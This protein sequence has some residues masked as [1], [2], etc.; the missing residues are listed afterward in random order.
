MI[1]A[2]VTRNAITLIALLWLAV[3]AYSQRATVSVAGQIRDSSNAAVPT[4]RV[5]VRNLSTG[6]ERSVLSNEEG[7]YVVSALQAGSY[8]VTVSHEGFQVYQVS[9]LLLQVDQQATVNVELRVGSVADTVNVMADAA[10]VELRGAT[11]NTVVNQKMI[12]DL[13]LN[14][15][16]VLQLMNLT[17]GTLAVTGNWN[18]SSTR[19]EAASQ[20]VSASGG[21]GNSTTFVMDGGLN[22]DPYTE[23]AN[24]LPNPDA[25]QEFSFQTNNYGAKFGG[26]G[27]GVVNV[28]TRSGTNEIHGSAFAYVR[29]A[30]LNARN[31]FAS[32]NDGLKRNQFGFS[33]GGPIQRNKTFV[34]GSWQGTEVRQVPPTQTAIVPTA[35]LRR[36][37]F[38]QLGRT[39]TDP[40]TGQ[41][42][43]GNV[44]PTS[45]LDP[46]ALRV[47]DLVPV[48]PA[49]DG[50][51]FFERATPSS[52]YQ[53][54]IRGDHYF[55]SA[56]HISARHFWDRYEN[57]AIADP[58]NL[59]TAANSKF[60]T[61]QSAVA[62]YTYTARANLLMNTTLS[63][64]RVLPTGTAPDFP[65]HRDLGI[66]I[67]SLANPNYSVF[68]MSISDYFGLS[69]YALSRIPRTQYNLQHSWSWVKG[70]H[71]IGFGADI[72]RELSLIDQDFQSDGNYAFAGRYS[73]NNMADFLL[74]KPSAFN[75]IT[76]LYVN[77]VRNLYGLYFED[78]FKVNRRLTLNLGLRWNPFIPFTDIPANQISQFSQAAY[79]AGTKSARFP[80]LGKGHLVAGDPGVPTSG[81]YSRYGV[82]D[83][84]L[85]MAWD[86][87][88]N[89]K[90]A[91]RAG[92]GRF[93]DQMSALTY[94]RQLTS[95][96]NS[97]R[98][99]ITAPFST[100]DPYRGYAN[101]FP[102][103]RPIPSSQ[104]FP[105]PYLLV[106]YDPA[107][108]YPD[109][110]Q[111][112]FSV[113]H[114]FASS[115]VLRAS[116]Q[117][118]TGRNLF[119]ASELNPAIYGP[120]ANRTNTDRRRPRPEFTQLTYAGTYGRSNYNALVLSLERR[121]TSRVTF[122]AGFSWQKTMDILSGTAFEGNGNTHPYGQIDLDYGVSN[123]HR[124]ARFTGSFNYELPS[125]VRSGAL[126]YLVNGWQMNGIVILQSGGPLTI[127]TGVDNSFSGINQD[128]VDIVGNPRLDWGRP[129]AERIARWFDT[130]AFVDNAPGTFGTIGRNTERGPGF[131]NVDFSAFKS[132]PMPYSENHHLEFRFEAFNFLNRVNLNNPTT[133][134][135]SSLFGRITSA[136]DPRILQLGLRYRF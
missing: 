7:F 28:V 58:K 68:S 131:A 123:F 66:D 12:T 87:F 120:G 49:D 107:F 37:D 40:A 116:Y 74:G 73:G 9:D 82:F 95:P 11:I 20:L 43:P 122:L 67:A 27:G 85:G 38:S 92:F 77:L 53:F 69:W 70:R 133:T 15:R 31:F 76:P 136:G 54:L 1:H 4:A 83:P 18:Q 84:R 86:V 35:A 72:T 124:A 135:S 36:G 5:V 111:W 80:T 115:M 52:D 88:G 57:P 10:A 119:H 44:I 129:T 2:V 23:V 62:N 59:L 113:E 61:S 6:V 81:V 32:R 127:A 103:P 97:V 39:I 21:R 112:N 50:L 17:P 117:G 16:N 93:H 105:M 19:P 8:S 14:G 13:P 3:P 130:S 41:P 99:D 109:I 29:N 25:V 78:N 90:T 47:L 100:Q 94:N 30:A 128:R 91:V 24:T 79:E 121:M 118:S 106:G 71:E 34:F 22:E 98:V 48:A 134:R 46:I 114:T 56:H 75:Q 45:R 132:V 33:A 108:S 65:G 125:P 104:V 60:W 101:P 64:S 96:P 42:F 126:K 55:N 102:H 26:R 63:F 110:Y 51:V 89:G